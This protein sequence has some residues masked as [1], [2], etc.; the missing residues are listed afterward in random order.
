MK[1]YLYDLGLD[2]KYAREI[3]ADEAPLEGDEVIVFDG[4]FKTYTVEKR[5]YGVNIGE[6]SGCWNI[7]LRQKEP[8]YQAAMDK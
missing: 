8:G 5:I 1:I 6:K 2:S 7:Y 4:E 3:H